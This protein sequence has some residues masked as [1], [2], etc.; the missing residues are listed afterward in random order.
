[1]SKK[2]HFVKHKYPYIILGV[3]SGFFL[4]SLISVVAFFGY[5]HGRIYP[6]VS[7]GGACNWRK[8]YC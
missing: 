5:F 4:L 3:F 6:G 2:K 7:V 1:M 8:D